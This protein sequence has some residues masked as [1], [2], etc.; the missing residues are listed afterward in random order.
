M[1]PST[2]QVIKP[3]NVESSSTWVG[4]I[5]KDVVDNMENIAPMLTKLGYDPKANPPNYGKPDSFVVE[6][7]N[8]LKQ[9]RGHWNSKEKIIKEYRAKLIK[10]I[11]NENPIYEY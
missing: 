9:N 11:E 4:K 1:E 2:D 6:N 3:I 5:P 8:K 7:M 10:K